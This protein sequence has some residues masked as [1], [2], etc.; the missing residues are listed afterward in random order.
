LLEK[1]NTGQGTLGLMI[2][3]PGLYHRTDSV[4]ISL[5]ALLADFKANPGKYLKEMRIV[6]LF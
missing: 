2:N 4:L 1:L 3:D 6:D 5:E